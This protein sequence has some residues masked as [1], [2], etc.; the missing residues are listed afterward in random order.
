MRLGA[1]FVVSCSGALAACS[2]PAPTPGQ[3]AAETRSLE[4]D[5]RSFVATGYHFEDGRALSAR[6]SDHATF[7][8]DN[9]DIPDA[10]VRAAGALVW[11]V[12]TTTQEW[13]YN[14]WR[15]QYAKYVDYQGQCEQA[16]DGKVA[17]RFLPADLPKRGS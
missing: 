11:A 9:P 14:A 4:Q 2:A 15:E 16:V 3:Y 5:I 13:P 12:S 8:P 17:R 10:C 1:V 6:A 7:G